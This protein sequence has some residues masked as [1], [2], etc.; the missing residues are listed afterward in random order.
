M[1][2]VVR[3]EALELHQEDQGKRSFW[4]NN[5]TARSARM[6]EH[7]C[8]CCHNLV[9]SN[10]LETM[11]A[12]SLSPHDYCFAYQYC[13][14]S[15]L[16]VPFRHVLKDMHDSNRYLGLVLRQSRVLV[17]PDCARFVSTRTLPPNEM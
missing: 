6:E 13:P 14:Y 8:V 10:F 5:Q 12:F 11:R 4:V 1:Q 3:Q 17:S 16:P 7:R 15:S 9:Y 2:L